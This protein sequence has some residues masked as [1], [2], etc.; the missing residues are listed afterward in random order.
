MPSVT[1][2]PSKI[3]KDVVDSI[4]EELAVTPQD[5][6]LNSSLTD[7]LGLGPIEISDLLSALATQFDVVITSE[8]ANRA[9]TVNDL[10][11]LIEDL[12]LE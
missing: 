8:D 4:A 12:S 9:E 11:E 3:Q 1:P 7:D 5:L 10:V 6:D 2:S